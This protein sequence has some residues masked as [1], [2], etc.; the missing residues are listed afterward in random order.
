M[1]KIYS[2]Q[3]LKNLLKAFDTVPANSHP[4]LDPVINAMTDALTSG[5]PEIRYL[6]DGSNSFID[7]HCV[8]ATSI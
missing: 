4:T 3:H 6:V 7:M 5:D 1:K 2:R 8:S